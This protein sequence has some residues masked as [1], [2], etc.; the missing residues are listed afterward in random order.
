MDYALKMMD[1]ALKLMN[2]V[3]EDT[4]VWGGGP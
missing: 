1:Y 2:Y 4:K 3:G